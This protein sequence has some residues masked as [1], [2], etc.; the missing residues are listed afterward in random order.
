MVSHVIDDPVRSAVDS[1]RRI[2]QALRVSSRAAQ[3]KVGLSGAQLFVLQRLAT[4]PSRSINELADATLTHQSSVSVVVR[5]LVEQGLASRGASS[6]D[7]R[8][9]EVSLTVRGRRMV[10]RAPASLQDR[11][12]EGVHRLRP[13]QR[14]SL[15]GG[16]QQLVKAM[17]L[18]AAPPPMFFEE[19][20]A[21]RRS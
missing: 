21:R 10:A 20:T 3:S 5:R 4:A 16:L 19:P 2:V 1:I 18:D 12:I 6:S 9:A 15:A 11:L 14:R 8:R 13:A 17:G 7:G